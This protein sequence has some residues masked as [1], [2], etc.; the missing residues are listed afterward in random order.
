LSGVTTKINLIF[1]ASLRLCRRFY[2]FVYGSSVLH[3]INIIIPDRQSK[4]EKGIA[5]P[6]EN[7]YLEIRPNQQINLATANQR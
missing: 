1:F 4:R 6:A 2:F 5:L 3:A 7:L